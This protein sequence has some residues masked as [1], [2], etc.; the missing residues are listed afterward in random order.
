MQ[1]R[2][3]RPRPAPPRA[4]AEPQ[5]E[6]AYTATPDTPLANG[7]K[8]GNSLRGRATAAFSAVRGD[9]EPAP[10][11]D[12]SANADFDVPPIGGRPS[13]TKSRQWAVRLG[14]PVGVLLLAAGTTCEQQAD[15]AAYWAPALY[16]RGELVQPIGSVAYYRPGPGVDPSTV[17]PYPPGLFMIGGDGSASSPQPVAVAAWRCGRSPR[18][19]PEPPVCPARAPLSVRV[20]FPDCWDGRRTDSPDHTAHVARSRDGRCPD[21]HPVPV[22]QLIFDIQY[23]IHGDGHE[24]ELASGGVHS[25]HADFINAWDQRAL[26]RETHACLNLENV[27]GVVPYRATG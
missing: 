18:L 20:V 2:P 10:T 16:D 4:P 12:G 3:T 15:T 11:Y 8:T 24:V 26:E 27:C 9:H 6:P 5:P 19:A 22:P 21:T 1:E 13:H 14:I 25:V 7:K 17:E 23:P